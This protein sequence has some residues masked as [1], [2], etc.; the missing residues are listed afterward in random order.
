MATVRKYRGRYVADFRDQF[1]RRRIETPRGIFESK[2]LEK[3][4]AQELLAKRMDEVRGGQ[5]QQVS[6]KPRFA[7]VAA[8]FLDSKVKL[9]DTTRAGYRELIDCYLVPY[10]GARR[11]DT[12]SSLHVERFRAEMAK[13]LPEAVRRVRAEREAAMKAA[14]PDAR[15]KVLRP[16]PRTV[17]KCL[18]LL[19]GIF[20]YAKRHKWVATNPVEGAEK[21]PQP[22]GEGRVIET[23]VL[24][25]LELQAVID[26]A[27]DPFRLPIWFAID[28]GA[29]QAEVLG[30]KWGDV[31]WQTGEV[32]IRRSWRRGAFYEPKTAAGR[33]VVEVSAELL[34]ELKAWRL[35]CPKGEHE[36]VF[37]SSTG[38]PMQ[39]CDL[40]R[41][42]FKAALRRAG[43]REVRFHD[44]RHS[45]A[46]NA[47]AEG[48]DLAT[49]STL[50]GHASP[51]ITLSTYTHAMPTKRRGVA[52]LLADLR[53]NGNRME[54]S[55]SAARGSIG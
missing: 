39:G 48:V 1:G 32:H 37:P 40:L 34:R 24:S 13:G 35:R 28:T 25:P 45:W 29:R 20:E 52:E 42:G 15:L 10:F 21:L 5:F 27:V 50:L 36:L 17:N 22:E 49:V 51:Q 44:L 54:T 23:N 26:H 7:E 8:Q 41:T 12:V 3:R 2:D 18:V 43:L 19:Y 53:R 55:V 30:L 4:A 33:R 46:S 6:A 38:K 31:N 16:G 9:R 14:D 11:I 47:L